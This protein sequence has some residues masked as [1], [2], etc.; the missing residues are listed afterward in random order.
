MAFTRL[1][2]KFHISILIDIY[3]QKAPSKRS[4]NVMCML[5]TRM[6]YRQGSQKPT[7]KIS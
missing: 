1:S 7:A 2:T 4:D 6:R 5:M 3:D